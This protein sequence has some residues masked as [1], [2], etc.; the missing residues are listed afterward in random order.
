MVEPANWPLML[1]T[2]SHPAMPAHN[3]PVVSVPVPVIEPVTDQVYEFACAPGA[4]AMV[5]IALT[6]A[7]RLIKFIVVPPDKDSLILR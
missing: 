3:A 4:N 5:V 1:S 2:I 6:K 7:T